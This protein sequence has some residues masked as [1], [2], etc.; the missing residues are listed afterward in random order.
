MTTPS[1]ASSTTPSSVRLPYPTLPPRSLTPPFAD[2]II[3]A[4]WDSTL[5]ISPS[6]SPSSS[7]TLSVP[8]K[9]YSLAVSPTKIVAAMGARAVWIWDIRNLGEALSKSEPEERKA[10]VW[11]K[12]ES[13]LK[14]MTRAVRC[15]P[16]DQGESAERGER[17]GARWHKAG[18]EK[19]TVLPGR[20]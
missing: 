9:V 2:A 18:A 1:S 10:D 4:S 6:N 17:S 3:S 16:N 8:N 13:S 19:E 12:R 5:H 15:M 11:Q 7:L 20:G 14:F